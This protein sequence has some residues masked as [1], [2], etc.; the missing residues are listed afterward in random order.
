MPNFELFAA[1]WAYLI[2][3]PA[4]LQ[5][6]AIQRAF[7]WAAAAQANSVITEYQGYS[8]CVH[9]GRISW[10]VAIEDKT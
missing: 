2:D 5:L 1:L 10:Q 8:L 3:R 7:I 6:L 9:I 4:V